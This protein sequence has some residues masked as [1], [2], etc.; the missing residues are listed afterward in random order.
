MKN[1]H[2]ITLM[3]L[4]VTVVI[5]GILAGVTVF[6]FKQVIRK[7]DAKKAKINLLTIKAAQKIYFAKHNY[8]YPYAAA[9][10][11]T[12]QVTTSAINTGLG[13]NLQDSTEGACQPLSYACACSSTPGDFD[14][15]SSCQEPY[16]GGINF[17]YYEIEEDDDMPSCAGG[18]CPE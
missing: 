7:A 5:V 3:E 15:L 6:G 4:I 11:C 10:G 1:A 9:T 18:A 2:A 17:Y 16:S 14:C 12:A 8:Y 13:L